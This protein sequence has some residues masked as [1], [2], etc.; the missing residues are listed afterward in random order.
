MS[1]SHLSSQERQLIYQ[2]RVLEKF[3]FQVIAFRLRRSQSSISREFKRNSHPHFD[4][5]PDTAQS[6]A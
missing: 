3:P 4:Y 6:M 2:W 1:Y 5:F